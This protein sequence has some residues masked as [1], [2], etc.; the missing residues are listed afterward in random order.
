[1]KMIAEYIEN[2][3]K[4]EQLAALETNPELKASLEKQASTY[5]KLAMERAKNLGIEPPKK[6]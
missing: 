4:F 1:M 6:G 3:H 2:A 5:R